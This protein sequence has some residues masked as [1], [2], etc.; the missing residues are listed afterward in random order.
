M[1]Q[2]NVDLRQVFSKW[3]YMLS[4]LSINISMCLDQ[5]RH[6]LYQNILFK[7]KE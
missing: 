6:I 3:T 1:S 5:V 4:Y 2:Y 7:K